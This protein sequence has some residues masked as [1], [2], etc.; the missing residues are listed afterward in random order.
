MQ[1]TFNYAVHEH[2]SIVLSPPKL[3]GKY[4]S[5]GQYTQSVNCPAADLPN[6][7]LIINNNGADEY[8]EVPAQ[9]LLT[10]GLMFVPETSSDYS[11][12]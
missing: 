8:I 12:I 5:D 2:L 4:Y 11:K 7:Y 3:N 10:N 1:G 6:G 9:G